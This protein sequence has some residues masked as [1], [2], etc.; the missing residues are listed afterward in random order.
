MRNP[1][2]Y[3]EMAMKLNGPSLHSGWRFHTSQFPKLEIIEISYQLQAWANLSKPFCLQ[4][5]VNISNLKI[6]FSSTAILPELTKT[7]LRIIE[8]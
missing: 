1:G 6:A 3:Y 4:Q 2:K 5:I 7:Y 8:L